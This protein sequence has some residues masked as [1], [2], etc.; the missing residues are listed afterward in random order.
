MRCRR[1]AVPL[2]QPFGAV[3]GSNPAWAAA[4]TMT[5]LLGLL[6]QAPEMRGI[7]A[8]RFVAVAAT[9]QRRPAFAFLGAQAINVAWTLMLAWLLFGGVLF[10]QPSIN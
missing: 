1:R 8:T 10:A 3:E 9:E 7:E 4:L 5:S 6:T 2:P